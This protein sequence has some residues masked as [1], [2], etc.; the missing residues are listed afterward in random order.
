[1]WGDGLAHLTIDRNR[2]NRCGLCLAACPFD[3]LKM[4][5]EI[6]VGDDCRL[7]RICIKECPQGAIAIRGRLEDRGNR[8][9]YQGVMVVAEEFAGTIH[10]V[11]YELIGKGSQL[12][13]ASGQEAGCLLMGH[14]LRSQ[15][16][17]LLTYGLDWV[18]LCDHPALA[19]FRIEPYTA[20]L[21]AAVDRAKPSTVLVGA[22]PIGRSLAPRAAV[23][24]R[25]GLTADCT[26]LEV[27]PD[28]ELVQIRPAFGGNIMAQ[29]VTRHHRPQM[30][31]VRYRV[32]DPAKAGPSRGRVIP[33]RL[34]E[35]QLASSIQVLEVLPKA[36]EESITDA[37]VIIAGGRGLKR[38]Q[39]MDL[40]RALAH[41]LGGQIASTR[42]LV[43][44]GW[45]EHNRQI[46]LSGRTVRPQLLIAC[47]ISGAVQFAA[48]I[49][50]C[51]TIIAINKDRRAPIF[52]VAHYGFVGDLYEIIP[53]LL[54]HL[55]K[56]G[57][58]NAL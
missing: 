1:L 2:C 54:T 14:N 19:H 43:E 51:E 26:M 36:Q 8:S 21:A 11:T 10:P 27:R 18:Y 55:G 15:A 38:K 50:S 40:L 7:C 6:I 37:K 28:G 12:A 30:A 48:G 31:T 25:T 58:I 33:L 47:G 5:K 9:L 49:S 3:A 53:R 17:E 45:V 24:L 23:R 13:A 29:I 20:C 34:T 57:R 35:T 32:M 16:E 52:D 44:M 42:P 4:E 39:D 56:G 46:G 22:T 41:S